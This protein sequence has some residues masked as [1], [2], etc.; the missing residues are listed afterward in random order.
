M[1]TKRS[2]LFLDRDGVVI[3]DKSYMFKI[4][5]LE[6]MPES[7]EALQRLTKDD[8]YA[9]VLVTNQS[10]IARGKFT[11]DQFTV[12]QGELERRLQENGVRLDAVYIC[13]HHPKGSA[14]EFA[15]ECECRKPKPGMLLQ[16]QKDL[17]LDL[18][19]SW[20]IGDKDDDVI[21]GDSAGTQTVRIESAYPHDER[22]RPTHTVK[23]LLQFYNLLKEN[24]ES[25]REIRQKGKEH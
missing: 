14:P 10:G 18:A 19:T 1:S 2:A 8:T 17:H 4:S 25:V 6:I 24:D 16:A 23:N 3:V 13:P 12:F 20:M 7:L 15:I 11:Y 21:C 22:I 5:D 9:L